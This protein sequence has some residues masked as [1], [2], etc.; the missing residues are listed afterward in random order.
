MGKFSIKLAI[1]AYMD[2]YVGR[3][4]ESLGRSTYGYKLDFEILGMYLGLGLSR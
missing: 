4:M 1:P 3:D 2:S